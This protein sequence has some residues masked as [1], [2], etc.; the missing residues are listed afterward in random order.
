MIKVD[1][2]SYIEI[3]TPEEVFVALSDPKSVERL[4]PHMRKVELLS[5][6]ENSARLVTHMSLGSMFGTIRCEGIVSWVEPR[7][8]VFQVVKPL[9]LE[10][11]WVLSPAVNG[12]ELHATMALDLSPLL[13]PMAHFVPN[14][15][16]SDM[17]GKEF[18]L[19]LKEMSFRLRDSVARERAVAA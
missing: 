19:A 5:R 4:L 18:D 1:R 12:T 17:I 7:E 14:H 15:T 11:R 10:T 8:I 16:V 9:P 6:R 13:G 2:R 3:A